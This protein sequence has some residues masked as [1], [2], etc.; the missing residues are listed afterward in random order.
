MAARP[1]STHRQGCIARIQAR[2]LDALAREACLGALALSCAVG[3]WGRG[4]VV[5]AL[6]GLVRQ[7]LVVCEGG[8]RSARYRLSSRVAA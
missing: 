8:R 7:G 4:D 6:R 2:V 5:L 3:E 1:V